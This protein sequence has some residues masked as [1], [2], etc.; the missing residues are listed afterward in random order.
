MDTPP[1]KPPRRVSMSLNAPPE[2]M[3][4][5]FATCAAAASRGWTAISPCGWNCPA[6]G[7]PSGPADATGLASAFRAPVGTD[8]V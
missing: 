7:S 8:G 2:P 6:E 3:C 4:G 1:A 5:T